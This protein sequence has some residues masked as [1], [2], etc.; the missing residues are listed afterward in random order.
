MKKENQDMY[1]EILNSLIESATGRMVETDDET[2]YGEI[3]EEE[4]EYDEVIS[5]LDLL[6]RYKRTVVEDECNICYQP[7]K[8][9]SFFRTCNHTVCF[10]CFIQFNQVKCIYNCC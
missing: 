5:E 1:Y 8:L 6:K 4:D 3:E 2:E 9:Y 7:K 10:D